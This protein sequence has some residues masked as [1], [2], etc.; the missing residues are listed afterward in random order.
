VSRSRKIQII[1]KHSEREVLENLWRER[2]LAAQQ[3]LK[4]AKLDCG[5]AFEDQHHIA[6]PD[7]SLAYRLA[8]REEN[9]A[10][11][12][13]HRVLN[14]FMDLLLKGTMPPEE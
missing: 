11:A 2:T 7:G 10:L 3:R 13:Y 4:I 9:A 1:V 14:V 8:L 5:K 12:D 6:R